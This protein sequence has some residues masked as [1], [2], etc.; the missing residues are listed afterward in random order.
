MTEKKPVV[1][2]VNAICGS[3]KSHRLKEHIY[4]FNREAVP[5]KF[6]IVVPTHALAEQFKQEL[7][8]LRIPN[9]HICVEGA[10]LNLKSTLANSFQTNVV[11]TT[12]ECFTNYCHLATFNPEMR[13]LLA[14]HNVMIDEIPDGWFGAEAKIRHADRTAE[15]FPF[16]A[17][18]EERNGLLYLR[19]EHYDKLY[20]YY[21]E[22]HANSDS[23]KKVLYV[24]LDGGGVMH[25]ECDSSYSFFAYTY[26][27]ILKAATWAK[28]FTV[29]GAGVDRSGFVWMAE[30]VAQ[31]AVQEAGEHL[32]PEPERRKHKNVPIKIVVVLSED[33]K[34]AG[35]SELANVFNSH[36]KEINQ[37]VGKDFIFATN[38]D[39]PI[40]DFQTIGLAEL[41]DRMGGEAVSMSSYGMNSYQ[42][43]HS[44]VFLGCANLGDKD[45]KRWADYCK[46]IGWDFET[47]MKKKRQA[48]Y[49]ERC[50]Q[51]LSRTSI[52]NTDTDHPLVFVVPDMAAAEYLKT[53]YF[54]GSTIEC[55]GIKK[56]G[57]QEETRLKVLEYK[58]QGLTQKKAAE[59]M[60][61]S[62]RTVATYWNQGAYV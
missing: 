57:R 44:A 25:T 53:H 19:D 48:M 52:R 46:R 6:L 58:A 40:C 24:A 60:A 13:S 30:N 51:F 9:H 62:V 2:F 20:Q 10:T 39:K 3:G 41:G 29:L 11:I 22:K 38:N 49:L 1:N 56:A 23:L 7:N 15:N 43:V 50:Y 5:E 8:R 33:V 34:R 35:Q 31:I 55:L 26:N 32:Q 27:P 17:W 54:P 18:L 37:I 21:H 36:L 61:V 16:L 4:D 12:H 14:E 59:V 28:S 42:D 47:V 45:R